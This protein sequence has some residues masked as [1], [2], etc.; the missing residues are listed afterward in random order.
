MVSYV[1]FVL[2]LF[3]SISLSFGALEGLCLAVVSF[4]GFLYL[5]FIVANHRLKED[6]IDLVEF[7]AF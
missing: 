6:L 3:I 2:S 4:S 5:C 1:A 7:L